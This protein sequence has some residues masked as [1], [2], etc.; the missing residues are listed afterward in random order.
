M[1]RK[2]AGLGFQ[3]EN[4]AVFL[5]SY[6]TSSHDYDYEYAFLEVTKY[7]DSELMKQN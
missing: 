5:S 1:E 3:G 2:K 4:S 7:L 6:L